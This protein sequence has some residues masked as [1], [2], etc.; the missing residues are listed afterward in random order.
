MSF[1]QIRLRILFVILVASVCYGI[2]LN[3][4]ANP[5][6]YALVGGWIATIVTIA[7]RG[8]SRVSIRKLIAGAIGLGGGLVVANLVAYPLLLTFGFTHNKSGVCLC[9]VER[10]FKERRGYL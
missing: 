6:I 7:E 8:L 5:W 4:E 1:E 2:A 3:L 10:K 9:R